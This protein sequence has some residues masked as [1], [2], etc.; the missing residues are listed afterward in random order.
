M[1]HKLL[2]NVL[3]QNSFSDWKRN[4]NIFFS[5][6]L[7][8]ELRQHYKHFSNSVPSSF[9]PG[10]LYPTPLQ[11][12]GPIF[13][14]LL[15]PYKI[16]GQFIIFTIIR[17]WLCK[18]LTC[19]CHRHISNVHCQARCTTS[20][21]GLLSQLNRGRVGGEIKFIFRFT[22]RVQVSNDL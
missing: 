1:Q 11:A 5:F 17:T 4:N 9:H 7:T 3:A 15:V 16:S 2:D 19:S 14:M 20:D 10:Y 18:K 21:I 13:N 8:L 12:S 6:V 22:P